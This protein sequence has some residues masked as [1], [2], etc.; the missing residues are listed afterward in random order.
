MFG[1]TC[2]SCG[3]AGLDCR[4]SAGVSV[5]SGLSPGSGFPGYSDDCTATFL[6]LLLIL[7]AETA[8]L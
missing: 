1:L 2:T 6:L 8:F 3:P 7:E 4:C 5:A